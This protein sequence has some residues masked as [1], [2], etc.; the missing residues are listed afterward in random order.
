MVGAALVIY[1]EEIRIVGGVR[2]L[3]DEVKRPRGQRAT[4]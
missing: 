3:N 4:P 2:R 1:T